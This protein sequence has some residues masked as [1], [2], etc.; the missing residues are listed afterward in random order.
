MELIKILEKSATNLE[1]FN[2]NIS[3]FFDGLYK[4]PVETIHELYKPPVEYMQ[5]LYK[6]ICKKYLK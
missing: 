3:Y 6:N 5:K 2:D 4:H 1:K